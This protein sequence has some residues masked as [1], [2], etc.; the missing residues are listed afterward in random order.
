MILLKR[1]RLIDVFLATV[2]FLTLVYFLFFGIF[3]L[4]LLIL[5]R[6]KWIWVLWVRLVVYLSLLSTDWVCTLDSW[7][8]KRTLSVLFNGPLGTGKSLLSG[9]ISQELAWALENSIVPSWCCTE[10]SN[11]TSISSAWPLIRVSEVGWFG[12][13]CLIQETSSV[14]VCG[15]CFV[16]R[17]L[18]Q[19][20]WSFALD[21]VWTLHVENDPPTR[22]RGFLRFFS[23]SMISSIPWLVLISWCRYYRCESILPKKLISCHCRLSFR[24]LR[25][26]L[27]GKH[28]RERAF[29]MSVS[30]L[31][32][33]P[34]LLASALEIRLQF[35]I[36][37]VWWSFLRPD[38]RL[39][40][41][42]IRPDPLMDDGIF[43][44][45][46]W[47]GF[48]PFLVARVWKFEHLLYTLRSRRLSC[49]YPCRFFELLTQWSVAFLWLKF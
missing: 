14:G 33:G 21:L 39:H 45:V 8:S 11:I 18:T 44:T 16:G 5:N 15:Q 34:S 23:K 4:I 30:V 24:F 12:F 46:N 35:H 40:F 36:V 9:I 42:G 47:W 29:I 31:A 32:S 37:Q 26:Y 19:G 49:P 17:V 3:V 10:D 28:L 7:W 20:V 38:W 41:I 25:F 48:T 27:L 13:L 43:F 1:C 6:Q 22:D 2:D